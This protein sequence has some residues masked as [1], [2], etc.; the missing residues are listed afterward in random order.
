MK[1]VVFNS[2]GQRIRTLADFPA[3]AGI[4]SVLWDGNDDYGKSAGSGIYFYRL[5]TPVIM[6]QEKMLLL[7]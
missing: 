3:E 6:L 1:L 4:H 7:K 5:E 2:S